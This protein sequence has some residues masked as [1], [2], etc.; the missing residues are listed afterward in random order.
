MQKKKGNKIIN[1]S[2]IYSKHPYTSVHLDVQAC[3]CK[4]VKTYRLA[5]DIRTD[6]SA[7]RRTDVQTHKHADVKTYRCTD[8]HGRA[9]TYRLADVRPVAV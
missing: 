3:T 4:D 1:K 7:C 8:V 6:A 5:D 2:Y 9:Q